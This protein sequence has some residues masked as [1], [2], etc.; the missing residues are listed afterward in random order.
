M[1]ILADKTLNFRNLCRG[2]GTNI[3]S[4]PLPVQPHL[5][6]H[7]FGNCVLEWAAQ[8]PYVFVTDIGFYSTCSFVALCIGKLNNKPRD[9][10]L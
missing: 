5:I 2:E 9:L 8:A 10:Q 4:P 3:G 7:L 6:L 1:D